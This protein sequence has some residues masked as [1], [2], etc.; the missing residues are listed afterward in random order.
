MKAKKKVRNV[1]KEMNL[2]K[3]RNAMG[4]VKTEKAISFKK[5]TN[6]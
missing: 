3:T 5:M 1:K 4:N 6:F 2:M